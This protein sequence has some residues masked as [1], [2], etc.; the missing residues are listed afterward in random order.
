MA[1]LLKLK[2]FTQMLKS[3]HAGLGSIPI[4][5]I[6]SQT[7]ITIEKTM[8]FFWQSFKGTLTNLRSTLRKTCKNARFHWPVLPV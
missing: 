7:K 8:S 1:Y 5:V 6:H 2:Q 4:K 3:R